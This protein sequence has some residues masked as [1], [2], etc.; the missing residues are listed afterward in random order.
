[1][2]SPTKVSR[3]SG[4]LSVKMKNSLLHSPQKVS[5]DGD[6]HTDEEEPAEVSLKSKR[7]DRKHKAR[8]GSSHLK[9]SSHKRK[10]Q[11]LT[12]FR[13]QLQS[14]S[15]LK[16]NKT[17]AHIPTCDASVRETGFV[18]DKETKH[19]HKKEDME[20]HVQDHEDEADETSGG[21]S[22][23]AEPLENS[24]EMQLSKEVNIT[25]KCSEIFLI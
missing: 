1:M 18:K 3:L 24:I 7:S 15:K 19:I 23:D 22:E 6:T 10:V 4:K 13:F 20:D 12:K 5:D 2:A 25:K 14:V 11:D 17:K 8:N 21:D 16:V 9:K